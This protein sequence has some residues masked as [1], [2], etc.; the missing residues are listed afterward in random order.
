[1]NE[2]PESAV[3]GVNTF[4][5]LLRGEDADINVNC[6]KAISDVQRKLSTI[7]ISLTTPK[8]LQLDSYSKQEFFDLLAEI[9]P[10][11]QQLR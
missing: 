11:N 2:E 5:Q 6:L 4:E 10:C 1:M 3:S 8:S 9:F 7:L